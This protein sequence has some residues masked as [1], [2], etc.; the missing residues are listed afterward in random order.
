LILLAPLYTP[1]QIPWFLRLGFREQAINALAANHVPRWLYGLMADLSSFTLIEG[2]GLGYGLP[3]TARS[4]TARD[5]QRVAPAAFHLPFT[6]RN[7]T[8]YLDRISA[9]TL[10]IYGQR[11]RTLNPRSFPPLAEHL[12]NA[13]VLALP[14]GHTLHQTHSARVASEII[15][16]LQSPSGGNRL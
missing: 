14:A 13:R 10:L 11:D 6:A 8:P 2:Q 15:D 3:K 16:F 4:Q 9:P 7:L 12:P 5:Y 1:A